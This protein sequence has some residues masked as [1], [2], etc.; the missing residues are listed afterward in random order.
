MIGVQMRLLLAQGQYHAGD[1][2]DQIEP[3]IDNPLAYDVVPLVARVEAAAALV[4]HDPE[5]PGR[6]ARLVGMLGKVR[7]SVGP[8]GY[9]A[10]TSKPG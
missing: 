7:D 4:D 9:L 10:R 3:M 2:V 1:A 8:D 6:I 5:A